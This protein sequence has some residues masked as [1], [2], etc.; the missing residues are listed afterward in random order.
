MFYIHNAKIVTPQHTIDNGAL[1]TDG[2]KIRAVGPEGAFSCPEGVTQVD[3]GGK[4]LVP[5]LIEMQLNGGFGNDFTADPTTIWEVAGDLAQFGITTFLPTVITSSLPNT[6]KARKVITEGRP[7]GYKGCNP[8]GLHLEGP[9]L[10]PEKKGAHNEDYICTA[11]EENIEGWSPDGGVRLVT[12]APEMPDALEAVKTLSKRGVVVSAGHTQATY[13]EAMAGF[14]AGIT[15]G[16]HLFNAMPPIHHRKPGLPGA[17]L[18]DERVTVGVI[19]DGVHV[20]P[21]LIKVVWEVLGPKRMNSVT[22][23]LAAMGLP[24]GSKCQLGD[25]NVIVTEKVCTLEDGTISGAVISLDRGLRNLI[26]FTGCT[27][28]EA[29]ETM[30]TTPARCLGL[31]GKI[32]VL[33]AGAQADMVLLDKNYMV[34]TT[35]TSGELVHRK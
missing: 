6:V 2:D 21:S 12:L 22:D 18:Y 20:H 10:N 26:E 19:V 15:Y 9:F 34:D 3:A 1:L 23:A 7:A 25:Y 24:P 8:L 35:F 4:Y 14:D 27:L 33:E 32:G 29:L 11:R 31:E 13:E 30:T 16:T 5:G 28:G 17:L